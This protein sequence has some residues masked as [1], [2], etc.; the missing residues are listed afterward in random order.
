MARAL[1]D[2]RRSRVLAA[3]VE[4]M[5]AR[6]AAARFGIGIS[7]AI[8]WIAN[9]RQGQ[10]TPARQ[11]RRGGSRLD[12]HEAF[13]VGM[14]EAK[15][16]FP[17]AVANS[18]SGCASVA[19]HS[20]KDRTCTGAATGSRDETRQD[21]FDSQSDLDPARLVF[22]DEAGLSTKMCLIPDFEVQS[23]PLTVGCSTALSGEDEAII[24]AFRRP[25]LLP[26]DDCLHSLQATIPHLTR[27]SLHRCLQ[28]HGIEST[29]SIRCPDN[30]HG[31]T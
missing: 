14:I 3:S 24:V 25:T 29:S 7:T 6:S 9:A 10:L 1:S 11:G 22:I 27:S 15:S 23:Y 31:A 26:L 28:R 18:T 30:I 12:A 20:R 16:R 8:A 5:S 17:S 13:I 19:G 4:G 21:W 2:D